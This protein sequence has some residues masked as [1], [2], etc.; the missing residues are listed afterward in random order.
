MAGVTIA[1]PRVNGADRAAASMYCLSGPESPKRYRHEVVVGIQSGRTWGVFAGDLYYRHIEHDLR[2]TAHLIDTSRCGVYIMNGEYDPGTGIE[3]GQGAC[4]YDPGGQVHRI[5]GP[6][7]FPND[8]RF[9]EIQ[10][11]YPVGPEGD[12]RRDLSVGA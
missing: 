6:W 8:G 1:I 11:V 12:C 3:E 5:A 7:S 4:C 9:S 2:D 10:T